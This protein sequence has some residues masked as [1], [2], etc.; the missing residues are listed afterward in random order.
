MPRSRSSYD[1]DRARS[2][3][4]SAIMWTRLV[5]CAILAG[6]RL[7]QLSVIGGGPD[8]GSGG[9]DGGSNCFQKWMDHQVKIDPSTV[10]EVSELSLP[11]VD[12]RNPWISEDGTQMYFARNETQGPSSRIYSTSW[13]PKMQQFTS[14][15]MV[16]ELNLSGDMNDGRPW[17]TPDKLT[18]VLPIERSE[19][20]A[21]LMMA[22]KLPTDQIFPTPTTDQLGCV[23]TFDSGSKH[24]DPFLTPD[25]LRLYLA[26]AA[27]PAK[28][29]FQLLIATRFDVTDKF[30]TPI[31]VP[32]TE[33]FTGSLGDPALYNEERLLVFSSIIGNNAD[34]YYA[35][36]MK[37]SDDFGSQTPIPAVND[38]GG[39]ETTDMDI[40][41][42]A[43]GC[44][45]YFASIR[46]RDN[47]E[48]DENFHIFHAQVTQ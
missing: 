13:D 19:Q 11:N 6:C 38:P 36:R 31:Q 34:L 2:R 26:A 10:K 7:P 24:N 39:Q 18:I 1:G 46:K 32:G 5:S 40:I 27:D 44:E 28:A 35:T 30:R 14:P 17:L 21:A 22:T 29:T 45:L 9:P 42:T 25:R 3:L 20:P 33:K 15:M 41:L 47:G 8:G 37:S 43:D 48:L 16:S 12:S 4:S 23:N